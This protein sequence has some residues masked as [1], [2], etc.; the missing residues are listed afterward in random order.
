LPDTLEFRLGTDPLNEDTDGDG[1]SDGLEIL[2]R[3]GYMGALKGIT[4]TWPR[5]VHTWG[6]AI[7]TTRRDLFNPLRRDVFLRLVWQ[8]DAEIRQMIDVTEQVWSTSKKACSTA[9]K[10]PFLKRG[11]FTKGWGDS[12]WLDRLVESSPTLRQLWSFRRIFAVQTTPSTSMSTR[13]R[14]EESRPSCPDRWR[15]VVSTEERTPDRPYCFDLNGDGR[16]DILPLS[17]RF[18]CQSATL[19]TI[20]QR[21]RLSRGSWRVVCDPFVFLGA[22]CRI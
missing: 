19:S 11:E 5:S 7:D 18:D 6:W 1:Y 10:Y 15:G 2:G 20:D 12:A 21:E 9:V 13:R 14:L 22:G 4:A 8:S 16:F 3:Q 17:M